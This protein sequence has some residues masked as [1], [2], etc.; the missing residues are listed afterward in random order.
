MLRLFKLWV[1][2]SSQ[3]QNPDRI[4]GESHT[5][6]IQKLVIRIDDCSIEANVDRCTFWVPWALNVT[7]YCRLH[8]QARDGFASYNNVQV[9]PLGTIPSS[10]SR[11][12]NGLMHF[13]ATGP[14]DLLNN[15]NVRI[16]GS[17]FHTRPT[18]GAG[19]SSPPALP[20]AR[21]PLAPSTLVALD[22]E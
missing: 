16:T 2:W 12:Q 10:S 13:L 4:Y 21:N 9:S 17:T 19:S 6:K 18:R 3:I 1:A 5:P 11:M 7:S 22:M 20:D 14:G 8:V 15:L